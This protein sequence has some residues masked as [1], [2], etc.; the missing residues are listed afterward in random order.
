MVILWLGPL[1]QPLPMCVLACIILVALK[2]LFMQV[3]ELKPLWRLSKI[4]WAIWVFSCVVTIASDLMEG[5]VMSIAFAMFTVVLRS[6]WPQTYSLGPL[7]DTEQYR[8]VGEYKSAV[9]MAGIRVVC[10][11]SPL[12]FTNVELFKR[13]VHETARYLELNQAGDQTIEPKAHPQVHLQKFII[14]LLSI[15]A[16]VSSKE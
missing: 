3:T 10:F 12:L 6:Q 1:L 9:E 2:G 14:L 7:P 11:D 8:N 4:D 15:S 5:L 16:L 13:M